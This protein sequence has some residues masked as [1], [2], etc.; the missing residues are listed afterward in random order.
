MTKGMKMSQNSREPCRARAEL[1]RESFCVSP[2]AEAGVG[3]FAG[4]KKEGTQR[5]VAL[6]L[7]SVTSS[8]Q[9][10]DGIISRGDLR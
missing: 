9:G 7:L 3:G 6:V 1:P 8:S 2:E 5:T 10:Q 4:M